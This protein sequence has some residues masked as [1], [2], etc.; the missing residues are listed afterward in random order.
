MLVVFDLSISVRGPWDAEA[1]SA[2]RGAQNQSMSTFRLQ[3]APRLAVPRK[4]QGSPS[5]MRERWA[6][7]SPGQVNCLTSFFYLSQYRKSHEEQKATWIRFREEG[8]RMGCS[9]STSSRSKDRQSWGLAAGLCDAIR[10]SSPNVTRTRRATLTNS[11][12]VKLRRAPAEASAESTPTV[13]RR[14]A[15]WP[16]EHGNSVLVQCR[17]GGIVWPSKDALRLPAM[18]PSGE[19]LPARP[20]GVEGTVG[21]TMASSGAKRSENKSI[22]TFFMKRGAIIDRSGVC[23][24]ASS[25][26]IDVLARTPVADNCGA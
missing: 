25:C 19:M 26:A 20:M 1:R 9:E 4:A 16:R 17:V 18:V 13:P 8:S 15:S 7:M 23:V 3:Q 22:H 14:G 2:A 11:I 10:R 21:A 5:I 12:C 6:Q 24:Y